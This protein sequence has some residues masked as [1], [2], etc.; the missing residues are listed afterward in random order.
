VTIT[1]IP[2][3]SALEFIV[4]IAAFGREI[5][6][7]V[8]QTSGGFTAS[9][10]RLNALSE[11]LTVEVAATSSFFPKLFARRAQG[12]LRKWGR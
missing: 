7:K 3:K 12:K 10:F 5:F 2:G 9:R 8:Y 4:S 11:E 1:E 6:N